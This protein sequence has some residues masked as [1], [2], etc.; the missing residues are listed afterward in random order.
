[1][2]L[3]TGD[4]CGLLKEF[5]PEIAHRKQGAGEVTKKSDIILPARFDIMQKINSH[6]GIQRVDP[7]ERQ[8]R[9]RGIVSLTMLQDDNENDFQFA[10]LRSNGSVQLWQGQRPELTKQNKNKFA[11]YQQL[12]VHAGDIFEQAKSS[13]LDQVP[14]QPLAMECIK[15]S[16]R[17]VACDT[18]GTMVVLKP[19]NT[20]E[21]PS[22]VHHFAAFDNTPDNITLTYTKGKVMNRQLASAMVVHPDDGTAAIGGRERDVR[23][24][25]LETGKATW[26]A[27]NLPPDPQT[28]LQQPIWPSS[29]AF[30]GH[31]ESRVLAAGTAWGQVRLYDVRMPP[32][33][34]TSILRRPKAYT[35]LE[36]REHRITAICPVSD[37]H[38]VAGDTTGDLHALDR[39]Y[40][41]NGQEQRQQHV[42]SSTRS[43]T[44][45]YVG[46]SGSI[47]QLIK[48]ATLPILAAVG[49]DRILRTYDTNKQTNIDCV[50]L[51]QR[52][53][54][55]LM[56]QEELL[57]DSE[58]ADDIAL[59]ATVND[60]GDMDQEDVVQ[61][62]V[63]SDDDDDSDDESDDGNQDVVDDK[64]NGKKRQQNANESSS[65]EGDDDDDEDS[66]DEEADQNEQEQ[67]AA[68][69]SDSES[70]EEEEDDDNDDEQESSEDEAP[71]KRRRR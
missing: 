54:C 25:D 60:D 44:G 13:I 1:M 66:S 4:E 62:Y 37:H 26:K 57:E 19:N 36:S 59:A 12:S 70:S 34:T 39:R 28:L 23:L 8:T 50:Y 63:D 5:V 21:Q 27:K 41:F 46:P 45:R 53:N 33:Q 38:I 35:P 68:T 49:C 17:L 69:R 24:I 40:N 55:V 42:D 22:I 6:H 7:A 58:E 43:S 18:H 31:N 51:K 20:T 48:H 67:S 3:I 29:L 65:D 52:L 64:R 47:R 32:H 16:N 15:K 56:C 10:S 71:R 9:E 11:H 2:R 30:W 61:D 14:V